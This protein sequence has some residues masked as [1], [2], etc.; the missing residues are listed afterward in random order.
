VHGRQLT[1]VVGFQ[2]T[3]PRTANLTAASGGRGRAL[4]SLAASQG[5]RWA[6]GLITL[7]DLS[8][9]ATHISG[10]GVWVID[11]RLSMDSWNKISPC[12]RYPQGKTPIRSPEWPD[13]NPLYCGCSSFAFAIWNWVKTIFTFT[14]QL[15]QNLVTSHR[16]LVPSE[17]LGVHWG[18]IMDPLHGLSLRC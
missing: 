15:L 18:R 2:G 9:T 14:S 5:Q 6:I 13:S 7:T 16:S 8:H 3:G 17:S 1:V 10:Y 11:R 4:V 12:T